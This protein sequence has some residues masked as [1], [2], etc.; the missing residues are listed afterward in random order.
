MFP[1]TLLP[2]NQDGW[3]PLLL[4]SVPLSSKFHTPSSSSPFQTHPPKKFIFCLLYFATANQQPDNRADY[5]LQ[6]C[7]GK[8]ALIDPFTGL[9][10]PEM[11]QC[12]DDCAA[13]AACDDAAC[14]D[15]RCK[16]FCWCGSWE[17]RPFWRSS[18]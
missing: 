15:Q 11:Q 4:S 12:E 10:N 7:S 2:Y 6:T 18:K 14:N 3:I 5:C 9:L 1:D 16:D 13:C 17:D 8:F